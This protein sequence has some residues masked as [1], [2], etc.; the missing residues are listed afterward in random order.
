MV[1][2]ELIVY[3]GAGHGFGVGQEGAIKATEE[4]AQ[5]PSEADAFIQENRGFNQ[6]TAG[7]EPAA[8]EKESAED[9]SENALETEMPATAEAA[10]SKEA[11]TTNIIGINSET[12]SVTVEYYDGTEILQTEEDG[13]I[14]VQVPD[15][16]VLDQISI[17][18][19]A[20]EIN[21][22]GVIADQYDLETVKDDLNV[23][24]PEDQAF[25]VHVLTI[26][27]L[28]ESDFLYDVGMER[29]EYYFGENG[30]NI[31]METIVGTARV[32]ILQ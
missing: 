20:G 29:H 15:G 30:V 9:A 8:S 14:L 17:Y 10:G 19:S 28:F 2:S 12:G 32:M 18:A 5:W 6:A 3:E 13:N 11:S 4:C 26:S 23:Y 7:N 21:I 16:A 1:P 22:M 25:H 27:D 24:L 31:E